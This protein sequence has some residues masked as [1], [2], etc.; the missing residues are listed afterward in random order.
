MSASRPV[1]TPSTTP[2][3]LNRFATL[4]KAILKKQNDQIKQE[5]KKTPELLL[6]KDRDGNTL[7]HFAAIHCKNQKLIEFML[8]QLIMLK[9]LNE[10]MS[11]PNSYGNT[12]LH[13]ATLFNTS[14]VVRKM[15]NALG[16]EK[17]SITRL[18]DLEGKTPLSR[19]EEDTQHSKTERYKIYRLLEKS[20]L[21]NT[22]EK[23]STRVTQQSKSNDPRLN[24]NLDMA[25]KIINDVRSVITASSSH[26][27]INV[28]PYEKQLEVDANIKK[29]RR[30]RSLDDI[31]TS[32][33]SYEKYV[34]KIE[35][36]HVG[37]CSEMAS[38]ALYLAM[39]NYPDIN[40]SVAT[41]ENGD[42]VFVV[43]DLDRK[44]DINDYTTWGEHAVICDPWSGKAYPVSKIARELEDHYGFDLYSKHLNLTA[45]FDPRYHKLE[46]E[47]NTVRPALDH[48]NDNELKRGTKRTYSDSEDSSSDDA[49]EYEV[50]K[51]VKL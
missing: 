12:P 46:L 43:I 22:V 20:S 42:H 51:R 8:A 40:S 29:A 6:A 50:N 10:V 3:L 39:K 41:I 49:A 30:S 34:K 28:L 17:K 21:Y 48:D 38:Y 33:S 15:M 14:R 1:V 18:V 11:A 4:R 35:Q 19:L 47:E 24:R 32:L 16:D 25:Y 13:I 9:K 2:S 7:V 44:A 45:K 31:G 27:D 36:S 26:P 37:N 5:L 23:L